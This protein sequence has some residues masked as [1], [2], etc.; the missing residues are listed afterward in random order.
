MQFRPVTVA[1]LPALARVAEPLQRRPDRHVVYLADQADAIVAELEEST[2]HVA[3]LVATI[4][5]GQIAGWLIADVDEE[6]GRVWWLG[7]FVAAEEWEP[8]ATELLRRC[9]DLLP[10]GVDQEE[11][12]VDDRFVSCGPWADRMGF[13]T[14][15]IGSWVLSLAG[16]VEVGASELQVRAARAPDSDSA[17]VELHE[18]LFPNTHTTGRQLIESSDESH[19]RLVTEEDGRLAGYIAVERQATG[20][21]YVDYLGVAEPFRRRGLGRELVRAGVAAVRELGAADVHLTVREDSEGARVLYE[22]LGF[23]A[24]RLIR[25]YRIGFEIA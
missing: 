17:L 9:R 24:E 4:D 22:S 21:G 13:D 10:P 8:T 14:G 5:G 11:M 23:V 20:E 2:H 1:D 7:P 3:S 25:P 12:A 15:A 16:D 19:I 6:M 18:R